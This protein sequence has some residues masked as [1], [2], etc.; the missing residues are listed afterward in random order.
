MLGMWNGRTRELAHILCNLHRLTT[1]LADHLVGPIPTRWPTLTDQESR[2]MT[3]DQ[4]SNRPVPAI[5]IGTVIDRTYS[6]HALTIA[7]A[8]EL[9][10]IDVAME[11]WLLVFDARGILESLKGDNVRDETLERASFII[12]ELMDALQSLAPDGL[13]FGANEGDGA[14]FGWWPVDDDDDD[15]TTKTDA[16]RFIPS[17]SDEL[18]YYPRGMADA[19]TILDNWGGT[20]DD[21]VATFRDGSTI[22]NFL[23][24]T[25]KYN[26]AAAEDTDTDTDNEV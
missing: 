6:P 2:N 13:T 22:E 17:L 23:E 10:R 24:S 15:D 16:D 12:I 21:D 19:H 18:A 7:F 20:L 9:E 1:R 3:N 26:K 4:D 25:A 11:Y 8:D 14:D 5:E